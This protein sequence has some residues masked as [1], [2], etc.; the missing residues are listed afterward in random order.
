M[1]LYEIV[2]HEVTKIGEAEGEETAERIAAFNTKQEN[3]P[4][5]WYEV[6]PVCVY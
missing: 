5:V 4:N 1:V 3:D 6:R 2:R